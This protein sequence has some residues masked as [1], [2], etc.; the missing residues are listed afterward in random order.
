MVDFF[1]LF[2]TSNVDTSEFAGISFDL[3][4]STVKYIE[5]EIKNLYKR[6]LLDCYSN[7]VFNK[8]INE[9]PLFDNSLMD[10]QQIG[11]F[12]IISKAM[13]EKSKIYLIYEAGVIRYASENER[14]KAIICN[15]NNYELTDLLKMYYLFLYNVF[16]SLNTGI[17]VSMSP[18]YKIY[19]MRKLIPANTTS[20]VKA[21]LNEINSGL[22]DG[23]SIAID[24]GD[25]IEM[26]Q[27]DID[28]PQ[29]SST[30]IESKIA[31]AIGYPI[32]F[33]TGEQTTGLNA[34]GTADLNAIESGRKV[35]FHSI[36]KPI[37]EK[38]FNV[39]VQL[40]TNNLKKIKYYASIIPII[41]T[42]ESIQEEQKKLFFDSLFK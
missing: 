24:A 35:F 14:N 39:K 33:V 40:T 38:I 5:I 42:S 18:V 21:Q 15:F 31:G 3:P 27:F 11:L 36:M 29:K 9:Q 7:S 12:T 25:T 22:K 19:E 8:E 34:D 26:P 4:L 20:S 41:E 23:K 28:T 30:F 32:S 6:I 1:G 13:Y 16:T 10:A 37:L 2:K 17:S